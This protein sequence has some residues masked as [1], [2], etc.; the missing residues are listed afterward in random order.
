MKKYKHGF[1]SFLFILGSISNAFS[2]TKDW[3]KVE[4]SSIQ[5]AAKQYI[6]A[7]TNQFFKLD[8]QSL[9]EEFSLSPKEK[10]AKLKSYGKVISLPM[11]D[12]TEQ[13]FAFS[14]YDIIEKGSDPTWD[15]I[16]TYTGQ[17]LDDPTAT[18]KV[19]FTSFGFHSQILS[20]KGD[21]YIDPVFH[22]NSEYYQVYRKSDLNKELMQKNFACQ[23]TEND[24][25]EILETNGVGPLSI[26]NSGGIRR[27]YRLALACTGEYA[28]FH[29]GATGAASAMATTLNR[30]N[31]VFEKEVCIRM[32]LIPNNSVLIFTNGATD[33]YTNNSASAM[34]SE[35]QTRITTVIGTTNY[36]MGHVFSTSFGGVAFRGSVCNSGSKAGGV[37]GTNAPIGDPFD[38]DFVAHE[39]GHQFGGNHT[40]NS[41]TGANCDAN[42]RASTAAYEPGSGSTIMAYAG[43]CDPQNLQNNSDAYFHF[44]SYEEIIS[45]SNNAGGN[46]CAVKQNTGNSAPVIPTLATGFTIPINTPFKLNSTIATD[47]DGDTLTY[48]WEQ[49]DLGPAVLPSEATTGTVPIFRSFSPVESRERSF[50]RNSNLTSNSFDIGE[51]LPSYAR[52]VNFKLMVR[53]NNAGA[54]GAR[55][56]NIGLTVNATGGAFSVTAPN[57]TGIIWEGGSTQTVTWNR[58]STA[59]APFNSPKVRIRFSSDG[60]KTFNTILVD[61][62]N[63]DGSANVMVPVIVSTTCRIMVESY[64]N[65][66][67]DISN[68]NFRISAPTTA[69]IPMTISDTAL[70]VGATFNVPINPS[71]TVYNAGNTFTLQLSNAQGL[72]TTP[73]TIGNVS[74][75]GNAVIPATLPSNLASGTGYKLRIVSTNPVRTSSA[76]AN[77]PKIKGLPLALSS[78]SGT[79]TFCPN[80]SGK[81]FQV[82]AV[83]GLTGYTWTIPAGATIQGS[84]TGRSIT[85]NFGT[86]GGTISVKGE[87]SCGSGPTSSLPVQVIS[88]AQALVTASASQVSVCEGTPVLFTANPTN[89]GTT[90]TYQWIKNGVAISGAVNPNYTTSAIV[91]TDKF[92]VKLTSSLFC[93][94]PNVDTSN[95]VS[96]AITVKRTPSITIE[97]NTVNDTSCSGELITFTS[98]G[99]NAGGTSPQYAWFKNLTAIP[100]QTTSSLTLNNL[101]SSD[102][103]RLR[104][105]VT[106]GCLTTNQVFSKGKKTVIINI[107]PNAGID[108]CM[109]IGASANFRGLPTGGQWSGNSITS[110]GLFSSGAAGTSTLTYSYTKYGCNKSDIKQVVVAAI[111]NV[112]YSVAGNVLTSTITGQSY[113]WFKDGTVIPGVNS[114]SY[115]ITS[116]GLYCVEVTFTNGCK[117]KSECLQQTFVSIDELMSEQ[118][119]FSVYP[120]PI[121]NDFLIKWPES[122]PVARIEIIN[123]L[124]QLVSF[125]TVLKNKNE[126]RVSSEKFSKG[127]YQ[128]VSILESGIRIRK[129]IVKQ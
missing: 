45:F 88:I 58:A 42:T 102:S 104:L 118:N 125:E 67:F 51:R 25:N 50:P 7:K 62:T 21:F 5:I 2:G 24:E 26:L 70:C 99:N 105:T 101:I 108:T 96:V 8:I 3:K 19:D 48:C 22:G 107:S 84:S 34:L 36:D 31:G 111:P 23:F 64:S 120:N 100:G 119:G 72:F 79:A 94:T 85:V 124:G 39:M 71:G 4:I 41:Q 28:T 47:V 9:K 89:G 29:G 49:F 82:S 126:I 109:G 33:P 59:S 35:N 75:T 6:K 40:F 12:G 20:A 128:V 15:L 92:S 10:E 61:S 91:S 11:P 54:G 38:I 27:V 129:A 98:I 112:S 80:E 74:S 114:N 57:T 43:I 117:G 52:A 93:G 81:I 30:V 103:I 87:N 68:A 86:Q 65:I 66:F 60:G 46:V 115:T 14:S 110:S 32:V 56:S 127:V 69:N 53:D 1:S 123:Q 18:C 37:T 121:L 113:K 73:L 63:N 76:I 13:R 116:S 122:K 97:T 16:K 83:P 77:A 95:L 78:I 90:P 106:G 44:K 17:G 55:V